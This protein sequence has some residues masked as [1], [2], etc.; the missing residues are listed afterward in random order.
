MLSSRTGQ[1]LVS[2]AACPILVE[3][4]LIGICVTGSTSPKRF[5]VRELHLMQLVA[6]RAGLGIER[7]RLD[8]GER[9]A[10]VDVE[11]GR[12]Y[13]I[14]LATASAALATARDSYFANLSSLVDSV[15]PSF[16]DWCAIDLV[17]EAGRL[18]RVAIR[19]L[20]DRGEHCSAELRQR[21]PLID[22]M[23]LRALSSGQTQESG[24]FVGLSTSPIPRM[25]EATIVDPTPWIAVPLQSNRGPRGVF[26]FA[27]DGGIDAINASMVPT[28]EDLVRRAS[29]AIERVVLFQEAQSVAEHSTAWQTNSNNSSVPRCRYPTSPRSRRWPRRSP[30]ARCSPSVTR[31]AQS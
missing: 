23:L 14:V 11:R 10:R 27:F 4:R 31:A 24:A 16:C 7:R 17:N 3:G 20:A 18:E 15:V 8:D 28:A 12:R 30:A 6:D 26:T 19:H 29:I 2:A 9:H 22:A 1:K 13:A 5:D 21:I 25:H